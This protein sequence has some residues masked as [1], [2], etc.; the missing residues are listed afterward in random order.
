MV[1]PAVYRLDLHKQANKMFS[2][3][4][5]Y[6][7]CVPAHYAN[8]TSPEAKLIMNLLNEEVYKQVERKIGKISYQNMRVQRSKK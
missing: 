7:N 1:T 2:F 8:L 5:K 3:R 4:L 6:V